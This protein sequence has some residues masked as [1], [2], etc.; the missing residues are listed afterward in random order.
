MT[1]LHRSFYSF[2]FIFAVS[3]IRSLQCPVESFPFS[4]RKKIEIEINTDRCRI[5]VIRD[6][7][8][9]QGVNTSIRTIEPDCIVPQDLFKFDRELRF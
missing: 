7:C 2:L 1:D 8:L 4:N 5:A 6:V 3:V 9:V